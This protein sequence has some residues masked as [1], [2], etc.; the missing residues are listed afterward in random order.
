[1]WVKADGIERYGRQQACE[2]YGECAG[3][4]RGLRPGHVFMGVARELGRANCLLV[5]SGM[6]KPIENLLAPLEKPRSAE[7]VL[8][9]VTKKDGQYK[10]SWLDREDRTAMRR[11]VGSLS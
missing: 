2:R 1:M 5:Q 3:H 11:T 7:E 6:G 9:G 4:H 8:K 10:V